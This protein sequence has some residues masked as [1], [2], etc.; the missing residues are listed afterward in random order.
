[1]INIVIVYKPR[2]GFQMLDIKSGLVLRKPKVQVQLYA[3]TELVQLASGPQM[4]VFATHSSRSIRVKYK[5]LI[6]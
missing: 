3:P 1:M 4:V 5:A 2:H 6:I